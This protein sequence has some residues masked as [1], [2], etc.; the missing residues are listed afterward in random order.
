MQDG[1]VFLSNQQY[2]E[3]ALVDGDLYVLSYDLR[4][5]RAGWLYEPLLEELLG[6]EKRTG[7]PLMERRYVQ[8]D[9][10][11]WGAEAAWRQYWNETP[12]DSW[13]LC[14]PE[15]IVGIRLD[16][17]PPTAEEMALVGDLLGPA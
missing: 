8:E 3:T 13:L 17:V 11:P 5:V 9:A 14:W 1:T 15:R 7:I 10:A 2:W 4:D 12:G 16:S 6:T